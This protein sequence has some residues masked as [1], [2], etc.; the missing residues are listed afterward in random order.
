MEEEKKYDEYKYVSK[1]WNGNDN[2][3]EK[4]RNIWEKN[5]RKKAIKARK[6]RMEGNAERGLT[7]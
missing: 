6:G 4:N 1:K 5:V 7:M 2:R 3:K